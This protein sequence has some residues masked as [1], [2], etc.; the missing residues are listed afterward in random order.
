MSHFI[1]TSDLRVHLLGQFMVCAGESTLVDRSW[2]RSKAKA[3]LKILA[4]QRER[5][6]HRE[7]VLE[8]LWPDMDS[9][10][11]ANN[12][13]KNLHYLRSKF[14]EYGI[15]GTVV[16]AAG[17]AIVLS[18]EIRLDVEEFRRQAAEARSEKTNTGL[19][20]RAI[21]C[22]GGGL[23]PEDLYEDWTEPD[24]EN[25]HALYIQILMDLGQLYES[26]GNLEMAVDR[27]QQLLHV[28]PVNEEAHRLLMRMYAQ[29]GSRHRA[30]LQYQTCRQNL[31]DTLGVDPE[32]LTESLYRDI[33]EGRIKIS[34]P[35]SVLPAIRVPSISRPALRPMYGRER[36][37]EMAEEL[38][39]AATDGRASVLFVSGEAGIGK[40]RFTQQVLNAAAES[41]GIG[42]TGRSYDLAAE[43]AY[44]SLRDILQQITV[45]IPDQEISDI[46]RDT[47]YLKRLLPGTD[48]GQVPAM[49]ISA[50]QLELFNE[51]VWL[52]RSLANI[53][54]P[55][56]LCFEDLHS[57]DEASIRLVHFLCRELRSLPVM[58]MATYRAEEVQNG[59]VLS[60]L[61]ISVRHEGI[62]KEIELKALPEGAMNLV[63]EELFEN[64]LVD[65]SI[66]HEIV[67]RSEGN[68]F[69]AR[70]LVH[71]LID[72]G[73]VRLIDGR[74]QKHG[75]G[76]TSVPTAINDLL[77]R[78]MKRLGEAERQILH[79]ASVMGR[80]FDYSLIRSIVDLPEV[81]ILDALDNCIDAFL[82]EETPDGYQFPHD[83][84]REGIYNSLTRARR[85]QLHRRVG[86][87]MEAADFSD[88]RQQ[89]E[90]I[91]YHFS[92]SDEPWR[93]VVYLQTSGRYAAS[94][95]A[96][97]QAVYL[98]EQA[99]SIA[100][101]YGHKLDPLQVASLLEDLGDVIRRT[102]DIAKS[103][104]H[105]VEAL[106]LFENVSGEET[107][108][109]IR[110][111][112]ALGHIVMG[113]FEVAASLLDDTMRSLT[114]QS[115]QLVVAS[116]Y[117][118]LAQLRWHNAQYKDALEAAEK[119]L[120]AAEAGGDITQKAKAYGVMAL[121]CHSLGDWQKGVEYELSRHE[122]GDQGFD[123]DEAFDAHL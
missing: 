106:A 70:E 73:L 33:I 114:E 68:P 104:P 61:L 4:L 83:L 52:L 29:L 43:L 15:E 80:L 38:L 69:F 115:P 31:K 113:D 9:A 53:R 54:R 117:W 56:V 102:G 34:T 99:I 91:G 7:Q 64:Q 81:T 97:E 88:V 50:L 35:A 26:V 55:L 5:S 48:I 45:L 77:E 41:A 40:S 72:E 14:S 79:L 28:D 62:I 110:G 121:A 105:F 122:L 84:I 20:E 93:A 92:Q 65:R 12:L 18:P 101:S 111:K 13:Y 76:H 96:N 25:L 10:A 16:G 82:I 30:L 23:L 90:I 32:D 1:K 94:V 8:L 42:V 21:A 24:R 11:A 27:L 85:Q 49:D 107:L 58:L 51:V 98:F 6:L 95:F 17:D 74:W 75:P 22:Y 60:D 120:L 103:L 36:E 78:R 119:A 46:L 66:M 86:A 109:R 19:F 47:M 2:N 59:K 44:L 71:S 67:E 108:Y 37:F 112:A 123:T 89:A 63:V 87:A 3:L 100:K 57:A 39:E 118:L 116:T